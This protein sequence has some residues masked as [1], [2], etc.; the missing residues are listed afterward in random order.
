MSTLDLKTI[1]NAVFDAYGTL[2][3]VHSAVSQYQ[4]RLGDR[5]QAV[6]ALRRIK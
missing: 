2:F 1:K 6:A 3:D 5:A 4:Q